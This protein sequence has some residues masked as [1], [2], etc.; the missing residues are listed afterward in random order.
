[1]TWQPKGSQQDTDILNHVS[2]RNGQVAIR[3]NGMNLD[4]KAMWSLVKKWLPE[5]EKYE[6]KSCLVDLSSNKLSSTAFLPLLQG[7]RQNSM[8]IHKLC[9]HKNQ[10]GDSS[11]EALADHIRK[12]EASDTIIREVHLSDNRI[13]RKGILSLLNAV[14]DCGCYPSEKAKGGQV[15]LWLRLENNDVDDPVSVLQQSAKKGVLIHMD[16][17][18]GHD[19]NAV[20]DALAEPY[21]AEVQIHQAFLKGKK[22]GNDGG[23]DSWADSHEKEYSAWEDWGG[24]PQSNAPAEWGGQQEEP[25][26]KKDSRPPDVVNVPHSRFGGSPSVEIQSGSRASQQSSD[27]SSL[28][29]DTAAGRAYTRSRHIIWKKAVAG[30]RAKLE[31]CTDLPPPSSTAHAAS[32][33]VMRDGFEKRAENLVGALLGKEMTETLVEV[34][35]SDSNLSALFEELGLTEAPEAPVSDNAR[36]C[37]VRETVGQLADAR[38]PHAQAALDALLDFAMLLGCASIKLPLPGAPNTSDS[39]GGGPWGTKGNSKGKGKG[40]GGSKDKKK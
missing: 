3:A 34:C 35:G 20:W 25:K 14:H 28:L 26:A 31:D 2:E 30:V 5:L 16:R 13:T 39:N 40:K 38:K 17:L 4:D 32:E 36:A 1:M 8:C 11:A 37:E 24:N 7:L 23:R 18:K 19:W 33:V 9:L 12:Q 21:Q 10:L 6:Y 27:V 22:T 29:L 15:A